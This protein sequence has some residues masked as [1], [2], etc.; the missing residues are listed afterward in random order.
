MDCS[1]PGSSV[2]G[3]FQARI[4]E[5]I[6]IST[7]G[8]LP[9]P[10]IETE[11][12]ASPALTG[13]FFTTAPPGK[14]RYWL[15]RGIQ[16]IET[17]GAVYLRSMHSSLCMLLLLFWPHCMACGIYAYYASIKNLNVSY[18]YYYGI[19]YYKPQILYLHHGDDD[20]FLCRIVTRHGVSSTFIHWSIQQIFSEPL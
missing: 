12:L 3:I 4:L 17:Q 1:P 19:N 14:P 2:H 11:S 20:S 16:F 10:G 6:A 9:D 7:L 13:G 8:V 18:N 5:W 15:P